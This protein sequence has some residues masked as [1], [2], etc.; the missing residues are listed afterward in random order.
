MELY[1]LSLYFFV[2]SFLGWC[3][4]VSYA[5]VKQHH[6]VNRGFLNGPVCPIYGFGVTIVIYFL[7]PLKDN[8]I[9]LYI[10]SVVLVTFLEGIT[11]WI[12]DIVFHNKWWDYSDQPFNI[13]GYVCITFSLIWG[14]ACVLIVKFIQP[15]VA[16]LI[17]LL[18]HTLGLVLIAFFCLILFSDACVTA[19]CVLKINHHLVVM[20]KIAYELHQFS[21]QLGYDLS[22]KVLIALEK[23]EVVKSK[24]NDSFTEL[25]ELEMETAEELRYRINELKKRYKKINRLHSINALRLMKAFP[26]MEPHQHKEQFHVLKKFLQNKK[27]K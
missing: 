25:R 15:F 1:Q 10:F 22:E 16:K 8:W 14:V 19:S 12:M 21:D 5:A 3:T 26:K 2:Y 24:H 23:Q 11:G 6:F 4:E 13:G 9:L 17:L 7:T 27:K 18:P 20:E